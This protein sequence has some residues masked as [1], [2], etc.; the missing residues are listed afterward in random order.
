MRLQ[1]DGFH[2]AAL[3]AQAKALEAVVAGIVDQGDLLDRTGR[4]CTRWILPRR[5]CRRE[6]RPCRRL[7]AGA[8][9]DE[10]GTAD[11]PADSANPPPKRHEITFPC[12]SNDP[13]MLTSRNRMS[14]EMAALSLGLDREGLASDA[15]FPRRTRAMRP[16][17]IW[18]RDER[19]A[20]VAPL[21]T[22]PRA[23]YMRMF[24]T[25]WQSPT[26]RAQGDGSGRAGRVGAD[27]DGPESC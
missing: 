9:K 27:A 15:G 1:P 14:S 17:L 13:P 19:S 22:S 7:E 26:A 16:G 5:R 25:H 20:P 24:Q 23:V 2:G 11:Q 8:R 21:L 6:C 4:I 10:R 3:Q 12:R 18:G